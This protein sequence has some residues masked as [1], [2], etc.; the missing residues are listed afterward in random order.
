M[1]LIIYIDD[2][3]GFQTTPQRYSN[4]LVRIIQDNPD[5]YFN[6]ASGKP[7]DQFIYPL[8]WHNNRISHVIDEALPSAVRDIIG[9]GVVEFRIS[10]SGLIY[11]FEVDGGHE[12]KFGVET[13]PRGEG[14]RYVVG[15]VEN[16]CRETLMGLVANFTTKKKFE[17]DVKKFDIGSNTPWIWMRVEDIVERLKLNSLGINK[18]QL[19]IIDRLIQK[20]DKGFEN[21][22]NLQK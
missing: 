16:E 14:V 12:P 19:D 11:T 18:Q 20:M 15:R 2:E 9:L 1:S 4:T 17:K 21:K 6:D 22:E 3:I 8:S 5:R 13:C 7:N 10:S